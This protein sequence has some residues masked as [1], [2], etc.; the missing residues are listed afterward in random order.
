MRQLTSLHINC[1]DEV[2]LASGYSKN[3]GLYDLG[4]GRRLQVFQGLHREHINVIKFAHHAPTIF[5]TS[6][7]DREA[8]RRTR[9][10]ALLC[11]RLVL[12]CSVVFVCI[13]FKK[14]VDRKRAQGPPFPETRD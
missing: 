14:G 10:L 6:S 8:R 4:T 1:T 5:A 11:V 3:V 7:F 2:F 12:L 13:F 9:A